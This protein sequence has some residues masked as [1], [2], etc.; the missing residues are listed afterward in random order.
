[1]YPIHWR[2]LLL[3]LSLI[4]FSWAQNSIGFVCIN[5]PNLEQENE[6]FIMH[7]VCAKTESALNSPTILIIKYCRSYLQVQ[8]ILDKRKA[9]GNYFIDLLFQGDGSINQTK[10]RLEE[11]FRKG[12]RINIGIYGIKF[13]VSCVLKNQIDFYKVLGGGQQKYIHRNNCGLITTQVRPICYIND[14]GRIGMTTNN[15]KFMNRN[16]KKMVSSILCPKR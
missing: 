13:S 1:M 4:V 14:T 11:I 12:Q 5:N 16:A 2:I 10:S 6:Q 8:K 9:D 15:I 3:R 7:W